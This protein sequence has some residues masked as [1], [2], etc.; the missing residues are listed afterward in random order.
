MDE[1]EIVPNHHLFVSIVGQETKEKVPF[2]PLIPTPP[3]K[4]VDNCLLLQFCRQFFCVHVPGIISETKNKNCQSE[5]DV[6]E[7]LYSTM[8]GQQSHNKQDGGT[9]PKKARDM[10]L[11]S[12]QI[13]KKNCARCGSVLQ[14]RCVLLKLELF[15]TKL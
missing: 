14:A 3:A 2:N 8:S 11:G 9:V 1:S 15:L 4:I 13:N 10:F 5:R 6:D 7:V 12:L